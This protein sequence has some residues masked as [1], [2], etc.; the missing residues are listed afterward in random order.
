MKTINIKK[1]M[2]DY[3]RKNNWRVKENST[4]SYSIGGSVLNN[5]EAIQS[6]YW[7]TEEYDKDI[8]DAHSDAYIHIH[9]LGWYGGYCSGWSL[10]DLI[11]KG[12]VGVNGRTSSAPARHLTTLANQM[13]NYIGIMAN[14]WAGAQAF[15]SV[16]TYLAPFVKVDKLSYKEVKQAMQSLVFGLNFPNRWGC[17]DDETEVLSVDGFKKHNELQEGDLIYTWNNGILELNPVNKVVK[18]QFKGRLHQYING[19]YNQT[20][21]PN[22]RTLVR[23]HN[24]DECVIKKSEEIFDAKTPYALP[25]MFKNSA[26]G[27]N[28]MTPSEIL[29][30]AFIYTEG[31]IEVRNESVHKIKI[32]KSPNR[33]GNEELIDAL[34]ECDI[35]YRTSTQEG[36]F[37]T[38]NVYVMYG[39]NARKLYEM[40]GKTK[41]DIDSKFLSMSKEQAELFLQT[42][43]RLDGNVDKFNM[44]YDTDKIGDKLQQIGILAGYTTY[45][46]SRKNTNYIKVR[47]VESVKPTVR[48]EIEYDGI[49]WCP[50]VDNGTAVFRK[51]GNTYISG[52]SQAPF[53]N[54]TLDWTVPEDL[55]HLK[56]IVGGKEQNF[57]YGDCKKEMDMVNKAFI[58]VMLEG[59]SQG[60]GHQYPIPTYSITDEFNWDEELENN[61]LLFEMTAKYGTPYFSNFVGSDMEPSDVRSMCCRLRLDLRELEKKNGGYFGAGENTGSIGVVTLN[62]PRMAYESSNE[63]GFYSTLEKYLNIAKRSLIIKREVLNESFKEGL[64][65]YTK[66]YLKDFSNHFSTI[67]ILGG[68]EMCLNAKWVKNDIR[69]E[70]GQE[71]TLEVMDFIKNKLSDFQEETGELFNLEATPAE[72]TTYRLAKHD[73]AKHKNII[74]AGEDGETPYYTNST[75]L[76]VGYTEDIFD[77]LDIQ[78]KFQ[79]KYTSGTV[80]HGFIG[81]KIDD[82]KIVMNLVKSISNN[83]TLPYYTISPTYSICPKCGYING[84]H[85]ICDKCGTTTEVYS[86]IT[87]YYRAITNWNDGKKQEFYDRKEY[88]V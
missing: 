39:D 59:D 85:L 21:T 33:W 3:V 63:E 7:L 52:Q 86:R 54:I 22:H 70:T 71:F 19:A 56:S 40:V 35:E 15:S 46:T 42:W 28:G 57:T 76:P 75:H 69:S 12:L 65:P 30:S 80:F 36:E 4:I 24:S 53:S 37:G 51:D 16:D 78:D 38:V 79:E 84:E 83:C 11:K 32:F 1:T 29:L 17:V 43:T 58:E 67:G 74:T 81:E 64:Y 68:N 31:S 45:R 72:S 87:G 2:E 60:R 62:L 61:K 5:A 44:Q 77:A 73:R 18:K 26:I 47:R 9:D 48:S 14:E 50:S 23:K 20:I 25:S 10:L 82:W 88:K 55:K 34:A 49:V 13:V 27:G 8:T 41:K 66:A 6:R